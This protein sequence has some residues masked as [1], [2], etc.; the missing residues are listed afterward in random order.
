MEIPIY[1]YLCE[2]IYTYAH[3]HLLFMFSCLLRM[4]KSSNTPV[5][6]NILRA[7]LGFQILFFTKRNYRF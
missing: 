3:T 5:A 1:E 6:M 7:N 2:Y 4:P